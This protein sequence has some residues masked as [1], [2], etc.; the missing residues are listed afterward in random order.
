MRQYPIWVDMVN[1]SYNSSKSYGVNDYNIQNV[2][3]GTSSRNS[4]DFVK[5]EIGVANE[6]LKKTYSLYVDGELIKQAVYNTKTKKM[7]LEDVKTSNFV[8]SE[9][10]LKIKYFKKWKAEADAKDQ[11]YRNE[12]FAERL[13]VN[14]G[15]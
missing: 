11:A 10:A 3:I 14:G 5:L 9:K 8:L 15:Y 6:Y 2:K 1:N 13:R 4:F 7:E 12:R